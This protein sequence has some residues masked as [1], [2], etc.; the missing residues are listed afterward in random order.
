MARF[1]RKNIPKT[2]TYSL[3][4]ILIVVLGIFIA[5]QLNNWN[6]NKK[7]KKEEQKSLQLL[8][9]DLKNEKFTSD[10]SDNELKKSITYL[11]K[12]IN[13]NYT[14]VDSLINKLDNE[15]INQKINSSYINLKSSGKLNIITN[16]TLKSIITR[17]YELYYEYFDNMEKSQRAFIHNNVRP[18]ILKELTISPD[19]ITN[20]LEIIEKLKDK[21]LQNLI[22]Y[23]INTLQFI[24]KNLDPTY[25]ERTIQ[26]VEKELSKFN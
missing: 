16:D 12:I 26:Y 21:E 1:F 22:R 4:E 18:Y 3:G 20:K 14:K 13:G 5:V 6:E 24:E 9:N 17:H 15:Y 8:L 11:S 10:Y 19:S 2:I 23:Q 25:L 7:E